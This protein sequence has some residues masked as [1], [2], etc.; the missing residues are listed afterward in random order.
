[1]DELTF[2][3]G[4][5]RLDA[6]L[7]RPPGARA[8]YVLAHGAGADMRHRF[9]QAV[10]EALA[11][12]RVATFRYQFPYAQARR[13]RPDPPQVLHQTVR[14]AIEAGHA[15]A[16]DLPLVA[17]GKSMGGR[18]TTQAQAE[19]PIARVRGIALLGFPL[20][21]AGAPSVKRAEHLAGVDVP[22][23]FLQGTR[24]ELADLSL[25]QPI[26][27][28]LLLAELCIIDGADHSFHVL[29]RS[30]RTDADVLRELARSIAAWVP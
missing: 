6:L 12:E 27:A 23:L 26:V 29:R 17:G 8:L 10:A 2:T 18:M 16:P 7:L 13:R 21:P 14:A 28:R 22:L 19:L 30:G 9:L 1:M 5:A 24:D 25:L 3:A 15:A 20:H 11:E 4:E